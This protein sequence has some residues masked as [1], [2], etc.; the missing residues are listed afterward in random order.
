MSYSDDFKANAIALFEVEVGKDGL[1]KED[2]S[3]R[4]VNALRTKYDAVPTSRTI[5]R[6][7]EDGKG[8]SI[9]VRNPSWKKRRT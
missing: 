2:A 5:V 7:S 3:R 8:V 9:D 6:W 1:T 4:V